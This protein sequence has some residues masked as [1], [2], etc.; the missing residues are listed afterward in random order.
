MN[1]T[2]NSQEREIFYFPNKK[3]NTKEDFSC[4]KE[5]NENNLVRYDNVILEWGGGTFYENNWSVKC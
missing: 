3:E 5:A 4:F 1:P 2:C